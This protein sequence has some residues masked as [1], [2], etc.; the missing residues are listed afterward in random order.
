MTSFL[1]I[2]RLLS[3]IGQQG[4]ARPIPEK[5]QLFLVIKST[6]DKTILANSVFFVKIVRLGLVFSFFSQKKV[7][8]TAFFFSF[9]LLDM[10]F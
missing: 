8:K 6:E 2:R 5:R 7:I 4:G 3:G 9:E 10:E 1:N